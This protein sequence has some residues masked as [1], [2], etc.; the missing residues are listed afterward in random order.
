MSE[1]EPTPK[2]I[3][4]RFIVSLLLFVAYGIVNTLVY[5]LTTL[6]AGK[7][8]G[9]QFEDNDY[10]YLI[11]TYGINFFSHIGWPFVIFLVILLLLWWKPIVYSAQSFVSLLG[12]F[13]LAM[14]WLSPSLANAYA[15]KITPVLPLLEQAADI[16]VKEGLA[17]GL[18][19]K[20]LPQNLVVIPQDLTDLTKLFVHPTK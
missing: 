1:Y 8:A 10:S 20:G 19:E 11:S 17:K 5:P 12:A 6:A 9:G 3:L 4:V 15:E 2:N 14:I 16:R 13:L 18:G 7:V